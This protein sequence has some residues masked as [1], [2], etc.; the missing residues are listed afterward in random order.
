[1]MFHPLNIGSPGGKKKSRLSRKYICSC[2]K[3]A[4]ER[5]RIQLIIKKI[6]TGMPD[7]DSAIQYFNKNYRI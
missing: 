6:A 5:T 1:M 4:R 2:A 7:V 3:K